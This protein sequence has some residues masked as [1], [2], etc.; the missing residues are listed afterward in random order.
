MAELRTLLG[1]LLQAETEAA[2]HGVLGEAGLLD[3]RLWLP[4]GRVPN[5]SGSFLN[6]QASARGALVEKVVNSIDAMLMAKAHEH[7]DLTG[8]GST[9]VSM[10]DASERYFGIRGGKLAEITA[11]ERRAIARGAVQIVFSGNQARDGR[12]TITITDRGEGQAPRS[13]PDTFLSLS[14]S[15]KMRIPFVQG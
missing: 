13:F 4:Y 8:E 3:D 1:C 14:A 7:G 12:P 5:N 10:R 11:G 6:Q 2:V 15:N 9:P